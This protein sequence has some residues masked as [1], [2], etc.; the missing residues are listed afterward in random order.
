MKKKIQKWSR[1]FKIGQKQTLL[2]PKIT[3]INDQIYE[4]YTLLP[5]WSHT[6]TI[7]QIPTI[8]QYYTNTFIVCQRKNVKNVVF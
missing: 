3:K 8:L 4:L 2:M 7:L 6:C 1:I 5:K